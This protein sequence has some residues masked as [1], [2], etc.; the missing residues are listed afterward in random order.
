MRHW[1]KVTAPEQELEA[2]MSGGL[3]GLYSEDCK[4]HNLEGGWKGQQEAVVCEL[5]LQPSYGPGHSD[6]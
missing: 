6:L 5:P 2:I 3:W 1:V 4:H